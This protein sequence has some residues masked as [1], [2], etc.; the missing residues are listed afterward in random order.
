MNRSLDRNVWMSRGRR[1]GPVGFSNRAAA[2]S[3]YSI[4][5]KYYLESNN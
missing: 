5:K 1:A 2:D 3:K 4:Y